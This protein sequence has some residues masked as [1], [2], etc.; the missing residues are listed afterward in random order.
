MRITKY[1]SLLLALLLILS[2]CAKITGKKEENTTEGIKEETTAPQKDETLV[3]N[4]RISQ[5]NA[6]SEGRLHISFS[7][8]SGESIGLIPGNVAS[9]DNALTLSAGDDGCYIFLMLN[10]SGDF[11][12]FM[13]YSLESCWQGIKGFKNVYFLEAAPS[14]AEQRFGIFEDGEVCVSKEITKE[15]ISLI[16]NTGNY[17]ALTISAVAISKAV[18]ND[19]ESAFEKYVISTDDFPKQW[20]DAS[21]PYPE[22][23]DKSAALTLESDYGVL[24]DLESATVIAS[25]NADERIYPASITKLLT[26]ILAYEACPDLDAEYTFDDYS[27]FTKLYEA[28]ASRAG[29]YYNETVTVRDLMYATLLPSGGDGA[30]AIADYVAGSERMFAILMNEKAESLGLDSTHFVSAT[31]LHDDN[32]YS[33]CRDL[34]VLMRYAIS[35]PEIRNILSA[36]SYTTTKN[37][38]HPYGIDLKSVVFSRLSKDSV[39]GISIQGGKTGF[40]LEAMNCLSTFASA[41]GEAEPEYILITTHGNGNYVPVNDAFKVYEEFCK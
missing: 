1:I 16:A 5:K 26:V 30:L 31:G 10:K 36:E 25:K 40:T 2:S 38:Y 23:T 28:N 11:D 3:C 8:S 20:E 27:L 18:E 15:N 24:V 7:A 21:V 4:A 32:H 39:E 13:E 34:S 33:T 37:S 35:I 6:L 19:F 41:E 17:P 22:Y 29:F 14:D 9:K 12:S